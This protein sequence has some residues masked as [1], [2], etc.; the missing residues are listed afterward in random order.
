MH[1]LSTGDLIMVMQETIYISSIDYR[2]AHIAE[3]R[4]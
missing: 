3:F 2:K 4:R 1:G